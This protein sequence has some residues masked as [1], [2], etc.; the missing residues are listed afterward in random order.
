MRYTVIQTIYVQSFSIYR[1]I[2]RK[3]YTQHRKKV[4]TN[5]VSF[6]SYSRIDIIQSFKTL[7]KKIKIKTAKPYHQ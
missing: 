3:E 7:N 6:V 1:T 5:M 4:N 2:L